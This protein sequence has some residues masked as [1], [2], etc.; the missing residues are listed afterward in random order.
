MS[1]RRE[2]RSFDYILLILVISYALFGIFMIGAAA[3]YTTLKTVA[4]AYAGQKLYLPTGLVI[5]AM[6]TI[7]DYHFISRFYWFIYACMLILLLL[8]MVMGKNDVSGTAR[9]FRFGGITIQPSEF[10]KI[11][12]IVFLAK[13]IDKQQKS[14]NNIS[15]LFILAALIIIPVLLIKLQPALSSCLVIA[16]ISV[17]MLF[18]SD[19]KFRYILIALLVIAPIVFVFFWDLQNKDRLIIDKVLG[20]YQVKRIDTFRK[21]E[22]DS[23]DNGES[24]Q[25]NKS[26]TSI[27][28]GMMEGKGYKNGSYIPMGQND[29][30][31]SV[32]GEQFGFIG[33]TCALFVVFVIIGKCILI[34]NRAQ[35]ML[36]KLIAM[37]VAGKLA[38]EVVI[39]VCVATRLVPN[40]GMPFPFLSSGGSS[41][42]VNMASIGLVLNV[43]LFKAKSIFKG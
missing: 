7:V 26:I 20:T 32:I 14:I 30:I 12:M 11:F 25:T 28:S 31:F 10:S 29:F 40:T 21:L 6:I 35:D 39:N 24:Y 9:W 18:S 33:C 23:D 16:A 15:I 37:G 27:A 42:W 13:F 36:G 17:C 43:G 38:F 19:L 2:W 34:A 22:I 3:S 1:I 41:M 5:L 8:V 4:G